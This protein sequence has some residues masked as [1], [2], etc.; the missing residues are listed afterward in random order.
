M[1][2]YEKLLFERVN[3]FLQQMFL[4]QSTQTFLELQKVLV[5][6]VHNPCAD[7]LVELVQY[8][9]SVVGSNLSS[10]AQSTALVTMQS[11]Q[12]VQELLERVFVLLSPHAVLNTCLQL[13]EA[14]EVK[15]VLLESISSLE[16][17]TLAVTEELDSAVHFVMS[18]GQHLLRE[19][20]DLWLA[21]QLLVAQVS[22]EILR[23]HPVLD[24][25]SA[26]YLM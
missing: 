8:S 2:A 25:Y 20:N 11:V 19:T 15:M 23:D 4:M 18:V 9:A 17:I 6:F 13:V 5:L 7:K 22:E 24:T 16:N 10:I 26:S 21:S 12:Q 14:E 1:F 3:S